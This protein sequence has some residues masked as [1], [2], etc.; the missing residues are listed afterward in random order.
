[1]G[2]RSRIRSA[3]LLCSLFTHLPFMAISFF[4]FFIFIFIFYIY[5]F[6]LDSHVKGSPLRKIF[7][8]SLHWAPCLAFSAAFT[9]FG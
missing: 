4:V 3:S 7:P 8:G 6:Y 1:M 2:T 9:V 5:I